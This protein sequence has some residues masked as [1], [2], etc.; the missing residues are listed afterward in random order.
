MLTFE[1]TDKL[2]WKVL[3]FIWK[4]TDRSK[5]TL[6]KI[7][8]LGYI[9]SRIFPA[10]VE[11]RYVFEDGNYFASY[12][13]TNGLIEVQE[14]ACKTG[15]M[16]RMIKALRTKADFKGACWHRVKSGWKNF[17]RQESICTEWTHTAD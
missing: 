11:D 4:Q 17:P 8:H 9:Q 5:P 1:Q 3:K 10:L 7:E 14:A 2:M 6:Y 13:V 16:K 12:K 15:H